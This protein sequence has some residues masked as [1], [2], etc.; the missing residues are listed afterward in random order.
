MSNDSPLTRRDFSRLLAAAALTPGALRL[1][2]LSPRTP[3]T[4]PV[5]RHASRSSWPG[6]DSAIVIDLLASVTPF[7]V[8]DMYARPLT[9]GMVENARGSGITA[10]NATCSASG[11]G[12]DSFIGT[13]SNIAFWEREF[14]A[15]P[16]VLMKVRTVADLREAKRSR[17][18]GVILGFQDA[19]MFDLDVSR[20]DLFHHLGVRIVQL[21]YNLRNLVGDG[22]LEPGNAG[23]SVFG[24][25][26]VRR[27]NEL[28]ML[29]DVS[30]VGRQSTTDAIAA[31]TRP[32][33]ATHSGCAALNDVPRNKPDAILRAMARKGGVI[34]IYLMPFLRAQGQ[35]NADD[36]L[37]HV[38][39][40]VNVCGEDHVGVGSDLS[41]TPLD[42]TPAFRATHADF[43]RARRAAGISAP[44]E[45]EDV[46]NYVPDFNSPRRMDLIADALA[47]AGH[48]SARIEK[49]IGGNWMRLLGEVWQA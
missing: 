10:V 1:S 9:P 15:H 19:T 45:A 8:P 37:R 21:T 36:F 30:H 13:V 49:I 47:K 23:L 31:S 7:N 14:A 4:S 44:G 41:I 43:V 20:V 11:V 18:V 3:L 12:A 35:P 38:S 6:Y 46:F 22:C 32:V 40:A 27:M 34:G 2:P 33:A 42:L 5:T 24:R 26:V 28:G 17:R 29:V 16:D 48:G 25:Q 39:H